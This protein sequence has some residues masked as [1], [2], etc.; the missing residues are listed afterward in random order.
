[1][2]VAR[3]Q[4]SKGVLDVI[5]N[6]IDQASG[7]I[8]L[9]AR[10]DNKDHKL[11]PGEFVQAQVVIRT[12]PEALAVPSE[13]V[14]HGPNGAYVWLV[15]SNDTVRRQPIE[16]GAIE[17]GETVIASGVKAG[18]ARCPGRAVWAN[19]RSAHRRDKNCANRGRP[20]L[21]M[22]ISAPFIRRPI[23]TSLLMIFIAVIGLAAYPLLPVAPLPT[24]D[25][26]TIQVTAQLPGASPDVMASAVATPLEKQ[27]GIIPGVTQMTSASYL[28]TTMI[29]VQFDLNRNIDAAAQDVQS[30][31]NAAAG[32]LPKNLPNPPTYRKVN[33]ADPPISFL[34]SPRTICPSPRWTTTPRT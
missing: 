28:G 1:M 3:T 4:L 12:E 16:I 14:Q 21:T 15:S 9:K 31:I 34:A 26:P 23:A 17:G 30:A 27:L 13:A 24:I 18:G 8:K 19:P 33:P 2:R 10:F 32:Y 22:N 11:W 20:G 5:N 29:T 25:F 6:Q 7:T